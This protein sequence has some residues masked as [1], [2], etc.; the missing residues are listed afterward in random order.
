MK[1]L[2]KLYKLRS[3]GS[4]NH[5]WEIEYSRKRCEFSVSSGIIR[6][7]SEVIKSIS[8]HSMRVDSGFIFSIWSQRSDCSLGSNLVSCFFISFT[9]SYHSIP[10]SRTLKKKPFRSNQWCPVIMELEIMTQDWNQTCLSPWKKKLE[11]FSLTLKNFSIQSNQSTD[12]FLGIF[13]FMLGWQKL[14]V[15]DAFISSKAFSF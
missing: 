14:L 2:L 10:L 12:F 6:K 7:V 9:V 4:W 13:Y 1:A 11:D 15:I 8:R 5:A 3:R